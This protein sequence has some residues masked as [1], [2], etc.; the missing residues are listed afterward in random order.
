M[1]ALSNEPTNK[2]SSSS[3]STNNNRLKVVHI[4]VEMPRQSVLLCDRSSHKCVWHDTHQILIY[5]K[6]LCA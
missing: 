6:T 1:P 2:A 5:G 3:H 4:Y